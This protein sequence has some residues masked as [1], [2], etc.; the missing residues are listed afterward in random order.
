MK[1]LVLFLVAVIATLTLVSCKNPAGNIDYP[2]VIPVI[3][4][5]ENPWVKIDYE[6]RRDK[7]SHFTPEV[8]YDGVDFVE[9]EF[10]KLSYKG[11]SRFYVEINNKIDSDV[12]YILST[13]DYMTFHYKLT[14]NDKTWEIS[15]EFEG[16]PYTPRY[17]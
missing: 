15:T 12:I 5:E 7:F 2:E 4:P 17:F 10:Y 8:T 13:D 16:N 14:R 11:S 6:F 3:T 1:H 9:E